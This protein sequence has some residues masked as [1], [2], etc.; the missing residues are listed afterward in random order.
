VNNESPSGYAYKASYWVG[1]GGWIRACVHID[2]A[3]RQPRGNSSVHRY[4][5]AKLANRWHPNLCSIRHP[6][7]QYCVQD[8]NL[9]VQTGAIALVSVVDVVLIF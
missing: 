7:L 6:P 4:E 2:S 1:N 9:S 3:E 5:R 8:H